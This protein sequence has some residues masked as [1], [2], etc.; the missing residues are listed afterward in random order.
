MSLVPE[1]DKFKRTGNVIDNTSIYSEWTLLT[2]LS[3]Y[4][5]NQIYSPAQVKEDAA[6]NNHAANL[7]RLWYASLRYFIGIMICYKNLLWCDNTK[8]FILEMKGQKRVI[9]YV[10]RIIRQYMQGVQ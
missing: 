6:V 5:W 2:F 7:Q 1:I 4:V 10:M 9:L 8:L 3:N